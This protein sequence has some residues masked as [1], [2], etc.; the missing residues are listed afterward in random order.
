MLK[1][2]CIGII[3][4]IFPCLV[5]AA[6]NTPEFTAGKEYKI[7]ENSVPASMNSYPKNKIQVIEFFSY[8]CPWCFHLE[9]MLEKWLKSKP[10][11]VVFERIPVV[12]EPGWQIYAKAY[13]TAK[14][15]GITDKITPKIFNAIHVKRE[16]LLSQKA[17]QAFFVKNGVS[18]QAFESAFDFSPGIGMEL[19]RA[20]S[21]M[22]A[23]GIYQI[24]TLV[25]NGKYR[26]NSAMVNGSDK[27][28][29]QVLS[30]LVKKASES[31]S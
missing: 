13:Y 19:N 5:L 3:V 26:T 2:M 30:F 14:A 10:K 22:R 28:L 9:P 17:M 16:N 29:I 18:K 1:K 8:G 24:P 21:L 7:I 6:T 12:F 4:I 27:K 20:N 25:V 11:N 31:E 23:W 15:L